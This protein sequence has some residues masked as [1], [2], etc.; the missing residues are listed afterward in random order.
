MF[1]GL[2]ACKDSNNLAFWADH[3]RG[4]VN[5]HILPAVHALFLE[6]AEFFGDGLVLV[7]QKRIGQGVFFFEFLLRGRFVG[8]N[9]KHNR[10]SALD[11]LE[12]VAEPARLQRSTGGVGFGI[13]EQ[14]HVLSAVVL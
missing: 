9:A 14:N 3:E 1:F 12:C 10:T 5:P 13:E 8:G 4:P 11:F 6:Y 2:H 7:G